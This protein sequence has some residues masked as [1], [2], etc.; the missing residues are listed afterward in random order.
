MASEKKIDPEKNNQIL[1]ILRILEATLRKMNFLNESLQFARDTFE[2]RR[3]TCQE[4]IN[5]I[6]L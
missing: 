3:E 1:E 6:I 4:L 2:A 5:Q